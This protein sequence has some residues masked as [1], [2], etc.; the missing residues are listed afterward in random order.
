V[1]AERNGKKNLF[2]LAFLRRSLYYTS[3]AGS[4]SAS[5]TEWQEKYVFSYIPEAQPILHEPH[6]SEKYLLYVQKSK[7]WQII[8]QKKLKSSNYSDIMP[9]FGEQNQ[10]ISLNIIF[11]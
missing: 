3:P 5:R 10:I 4:D 2:F 7:F 8:D 11:Y 6:A 1:Q 9:N